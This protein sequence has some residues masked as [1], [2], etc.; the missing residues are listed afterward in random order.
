MTRMIKQSDKEQ[1]QLKAVL[2][3]VEAGDAAAVCTELPGAQSAISSG[4]PVRGSGVLP[5]QAAVE[6][7][8]E[9]MVGAL[10]DAGAPLEQADGRGLTPLQARPRSACQRLPSI[11]R[12]AIVL[13]IS[14][15]VGV[16]CDDDKGK[17]HG[18]D[19]TAIAY[20]EQG[21]LGP[22]VHKQ[23]AGHPGCT[24]TATAPWV[25][26]GCTS[27][28]AVSNGCRGCAGGSQGRAV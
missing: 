15:P 3:A 26:A 1:E 6:G 16:I 4:V 13:L 5:L 9:D 17:S 8:H 27:W 21:T 23:S 19:V 7:G 22:R 10:L 18:Q 25:R 12:H 11:H 2:A 28:L 14:A 24:L 20:G